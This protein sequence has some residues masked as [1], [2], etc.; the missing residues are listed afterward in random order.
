MSKKTLIVVGVLGLFGVVAY[1]GFP[2]LAKDALFY[3]DAPEANYPEPADEAEARLQDLQHL[4]HYVRG[5][6]RS[7]HFRAR[8][9]ALARIEELKGSAASLS[10]AGF[11]LAISEIVA[12][13]ENG[14]SNVW[15]GPRSRRHPSM[16]F[17]GYSFDDGYYIV[18]AT[19]DHAGLLGTKVTHIGNGPLSDLKSAYRRF[20]GGEDSGYL[21]YSLPY[22]VQNTAF[23]KELGFIQDAFR[24]SLTVT[25]HDG[26]VETLQLSALPAQEDR[27]ANWPWDWLIS[28]TQEDPQFVRFRNGQNHRPIYLA[29]TKAFQIVRIDAAQAPLVQY[30]QN[31][32]SEKRISQFNDE[33]RAAIA[34]FR[35]RALI[36]DQR[37]NGGGDYTKTAGLMFDMPEMLPTGTRVYA[38]TGPE[39]FSAGI[40]SLGF[41]KEAL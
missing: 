25:R 29:S 39:T 5:Y 35:P 37:F 16:P 33:V 36:V 6:D 19:P 24:P 2:E 12:M 11:E 17:F 14:H 41:L 28:E 26:G 32:D 9:R 10:P 31:Y 23:L 7:Y 20:Y 8:G 40:S 30:R 18:A 13:G 1:I 15:S 38:I 22:L 3:P 4:E 34:Q 21:A 27:Q